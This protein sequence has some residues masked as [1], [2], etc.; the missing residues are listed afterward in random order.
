MADAD[1]TNGNYILILLRTA[2]KNAL[3]LKLAHKS[4][5][6]AIH[7][8]RYFH[9]NFKKRGLKFSEIKEKENT[10]LKSRKYRTEN[11]A[12]LL[13]T[14]LKEII[15]VQINANGKEKVR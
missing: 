6:K 9:E 10:T 3:K 14:F 15:F 4:A 5:I 13:S 1:N 8:E 2:E 12:Y 7:S 11:V